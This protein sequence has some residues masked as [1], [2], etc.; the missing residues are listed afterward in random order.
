MRGGSAPIENASPND[1]EA[2]QAVVGA[3]MLAPNVITEVSA[4]MA[5]ADHYRPPTRPSIS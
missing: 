2:E 3:M 5:P 1:L 4:V